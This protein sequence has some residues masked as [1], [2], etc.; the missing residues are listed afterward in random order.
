MLRGETGTDSQ[1][2]VKNME[3]QRYP[4]ATGSVV[5]AL[6]NKNGDLMGFNEIYYK[7]YLRFQS[8][9]STS[10]VVSTEIKP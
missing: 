9:I 4:E 1:W 5:L 7:K 10:N 2:D 6:A 3:I 8:W